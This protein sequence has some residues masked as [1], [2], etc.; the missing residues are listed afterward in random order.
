[1]KLQVY[2]QNGRVEQALRYM[3]SLQKTFGNWLV[4]YSNYD[5]QKKNILHVKTIQVFDIND[6][7]NWEKCIIEF[8]SGMSD[9]FAI[10]AFNEI[11][12]F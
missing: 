9:Q 4:K 12:G 8:I 7:E 10:Q 2:A 5:A 6:N 3:P 1:M 11:V